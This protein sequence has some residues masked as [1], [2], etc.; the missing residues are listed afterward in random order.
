MPLVPQTYDRNLRSPKYYESTA[1]GA[2]G[3]NPE[4]TMYYTSADELV[5][6]EEVWR[7]KQYSQTISGSNYSEQWPSY[8]YSVTYN[9]WEETTVS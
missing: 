4:I 7:G 3:Y 5:R 6:V 1:V 9:A 8:S 2:A